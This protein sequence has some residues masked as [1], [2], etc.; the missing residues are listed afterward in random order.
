M[1]QLKM[2]LGC[3]VP[4][5]TEVQYLNLLSAKP[6]VLPE[7]LFEHGS[8][9]PLERDLYGFGH[10]VAEKSYADGIAGLRPGPLLV[11]HPFPVD[12]N[13]R[14]TLRL[15]PTGFAGLKRKAQLI[16]G[17]PEHREAHAEQP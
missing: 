12:D 8:E 10:R 7:L 3:P 14:L 4:A 11:P 16:V 2:L 13:V 6:R 5:D 9:G 15:V 1:L 17:S